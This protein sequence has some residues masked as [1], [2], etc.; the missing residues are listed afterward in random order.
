LFVFI[1]ES[2]MT[3]RLCWRRLALL[4]AHHSGWEGLNSL[5]FSSHSQWMPTS[6]T[7]REHMK[8]HAHRT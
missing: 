1:S 7:T 3:V 2:V 6:A 5:L 8:N 4:G